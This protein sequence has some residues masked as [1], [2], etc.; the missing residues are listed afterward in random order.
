MRRLFLVFIATTV[1]NFAKSQNV[2]VGTETPQAA[3]D[4]S[5]T[6]QGFLPPRMTIAQ[7]DEIANP[8]AGLVIYCI[9]CDEL[10]V[11]NGTIW[12]NMKGEAAVS[13]SLPSNVTIGTQV[14][15]VRNLDVTTYRN[16]DP[17]PQITTWP[18]P[19]GGWCW[20]NNDSATYGATYGRLY[21]WLAVSDP[22]GLAPAGW[23]IPVDSEWDT[24]STY[25][26]GVAIAG[27][28][29]KERGTLL[30]GGGG[31]VNTDATNSSGYTGRPGG[32]RK[33]DG[34]FTKWTVIGYWWTA[35]EFDASSATY[36]NLN[37]DNGVIQSSIAKKK[38]CMSVRCVKD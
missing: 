26:G 23:H 5:S 11:Y 33:D 19:V 24:L 7:R 10:Q 14:W 2:G 1:F 6:T 13:Q 29:M 15:T 37:Y 35:S 12:K 3:L 16:G 27:G 20:Y 30:W 25:L 34:V 4:V 17:I 22:R 36:H 38:D 8:V 32:Y 31:G 18:S 9:D 28:K 21:N